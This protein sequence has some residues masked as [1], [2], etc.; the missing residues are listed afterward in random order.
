MR[1]ESVVARS[2]HATRRPPQRDVRW[3]QPRRWVNE[4]TPTPVQRFGACLHSAGLSIRETLT[5]L[6]PL[7]VERSHGAVWNW[8]HTLSEAQNDLSTAQSPRAVVDEKQ[9]EVDGEKKWL[10]A[11]VDAESKLLLYVDVFSRRG[12]D[13]AGLTR[14]MLS[15]A[16]QKSS[17]SEDGVP[18]SAHSETRCR[19]FSASR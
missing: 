19:R 18:T 17:I 15:F 3:G 7:D 5:I 1:N 9:T 13:S 10:Y 11:A 16:H 8:V 2:V 6:D 14:A 12:T 4:R